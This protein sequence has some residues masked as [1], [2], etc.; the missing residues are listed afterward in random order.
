M[1]GEAFSQRAHAGLRGSGRFDM[2]SLCRSNDGSAM[3]ETLR[4]TYRRWVSVASGVRLRDRASGLAR[5]EI[6][7]LLTAPLLLGGGP[8]HPPEQPGSAGTGPPATSS[9]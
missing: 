6:L 4:F 3:R 1:A 8:I 7:A 5:P 9:D 2:D